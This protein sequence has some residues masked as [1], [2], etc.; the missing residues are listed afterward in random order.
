LFVR[1]LIQQRVFLK[2]YNKKQQQLKQYTMREE[3]DKM[4][5]CGTYWPT[6]YKNLGTDWLNKEGGEVRGQTSTTVN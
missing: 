3:V 2:E 4:E 6:V 1:N 5:A